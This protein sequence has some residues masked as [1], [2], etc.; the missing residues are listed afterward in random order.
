M[1]TN[2]LSPSFVFFGTPDVSSE[3]L[4]ILKSYG[5][6]PQLIVTAPDR[7][8]GRHFTMT[9]S[10]T[11]VWALENNIPLIQPEKITEEVLEML[12]TPS[13]LTPSPNGADPLLQ[14]ESYDLFIVVAYGKILPQAL[15]NIPKLGTLNIHYSLLPRWRGASPVEAA[16]LA[17]DKETGVSIQNMI[18]KLDAGD[19]IAEERIPIEPDDT[20]PSLRGKLIPMGA[21]LLAEYVIPALLKNEQILIEQDELLMTHCGKTKKE[22]GLIDPEHDD[23]E[24][25]YRKYRAYQPWPGLHFFQNGKRIK[26]TQA[27]YENG[28]FIIEKV[29]RE[30]EKESIWNQYYQ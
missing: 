13:N 14:G 3:T 21:K 6:L 12:R 1:H 23:P 15:I 22:D 24:I 28:K 11:K 27:H 26:I 5:Y 2:P 25:M 7:P 8:V 18:F 30:G 10:S 16:I 9:P 29:I 17:G 4:E 19:I 20:T